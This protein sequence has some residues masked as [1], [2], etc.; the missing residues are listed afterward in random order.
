MDKQARKHTDT[1]DE[2]KGEAEVERWSDG[3]EEWR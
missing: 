2:E 1:C 3:E